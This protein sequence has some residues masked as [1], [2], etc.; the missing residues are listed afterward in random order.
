MSRVLRSLALIIAALLFAACSPDRSSQSEGLLSRETLPS[1][2][3][4]VRYGALPQGEVVRVEADR[5]IGAV[6]GDPRYIFGDLRGIEA[7]RDG[8]IYVLDY[9]ASEVR[10]FD[11]TGRFLR[12]VVTHGEGPGEITEANGILLVGDSI[13]WI[14]DHG[15]MMMLGV[16]PAGV[17]VARFPMPVRAYGYIWDG[18][19]DDGGRVWK[20]RNHFDGPAV[21]PPKEGLT[22]EHS[23]AYMVWYEPAADVRDSIYLGDERYRTMISRNQ[24]GGYT[25]RHVPFDPQPIAVADAEGTIWRTGSAAYRVVRLSAQGD[26]LLVIESDTPAPP[27]TPADRSRYGERESEQ[28]PGDRRVVEELA[29][30]MPEA[31]PV[32]ASLTVDDEGRLWVGRAV[33]DDAEIEFDV[34]GSDGGYAGTVALGFRP[35]PYTPIRIRQRRV[36]AIVRDSLDVPFVVRSVAL[37]DLQ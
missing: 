7:G 30:L 14:Q 32:I 10:A 36:Y 16:S 19:V 21:Y 24:H 8:T 2:T 1:G 33:A 28:S 31:K 3:V 29:Q 26:T 25:Y 9:Q 27:V 11:A 20:Q 35:A 34:F 12:T 4:V 18:T 13:L 5:T 22:E 15:K 17:E 37:R 6:D 23:R